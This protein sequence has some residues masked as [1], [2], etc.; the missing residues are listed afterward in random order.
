[1]PIESKSIIMI[2]LSNPR[3]IYNS[4]NDTNG[5]TTNN[6]NTNNNNNTY[7]IKSRKVNKNL[8]KPIRHKH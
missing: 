6:N 3:Q 1:M 7:I 8:L 5:T 2:F 4:N